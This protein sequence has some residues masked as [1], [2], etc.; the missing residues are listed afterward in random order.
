MVLLI[1]D[2]KQ[3]SNLFPMMYHPC[4]CPPALKLGGTCTSLLNMKKHLWTWDFPLLG[5]AEKTFLEGE[6]NQ[7]QTLK[8]QRTKQQ[9]GISACQVGPT[10]RVTPRHL[11]KGMHDLKMVHVIPDRPNCLNVHLCWIL[12]TKPP[13]LGTSNTMHVSLCILSF[14][15]ALAIPDFVCS[16]PMVVGLKSPCLGA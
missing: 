15:S 3:W 11:G 5:Q 13:F 6:K 10:E 8:Q 1:Q 12:E 9:R 2:F 7:P 4:L 16:T 14:D